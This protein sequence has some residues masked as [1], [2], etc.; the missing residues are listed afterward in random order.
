VNYLLLEA[1]DIY[2]DYFTDALSFTFPTGSQ[3]H[4]SL[5]KLT[6]EIRQRIAAMFLLD[7][8]G[9]RPLNGKPYILSFTC[10]AENHFLVR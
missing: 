1:L 4:L 3:K 8:R 9:C 7:S 10:T 2:G 6:N 5:H